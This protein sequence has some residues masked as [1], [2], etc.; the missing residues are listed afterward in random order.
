MH[1][2]FPFHLAAGCL[3][4]LAGLACSAAAE[5]QQGRQGGES[6]DRQDN[7]LSSIDISSRLYR[8]ALE[9]KAAG[10][11]KAAIPLFNRLARRGQ[12]FELAQFHLG[13]CLMRGAEESATSTQFLSGLV[14]VRRA[15]EAGAPQAQATLALLYLGGPESLRDR[16]EA[17]FWFAL[18]RDNPERKKPGF[19]SPLSAREE[20]RLESALPA[21]IRDAAK[22]RAESWQRKV[23][24]PP[25]EGIS[26]IGESPRR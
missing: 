3:V 1:L 22:E 12:G 24:S 5:A 21:E 9:H 8:Q 17:A 6:Q 7:L 15:A 11:C 20:E 13:E 25:D 14:W 23:W 4:V 10:D 26:R 16:E 19:S 2:T 18:F